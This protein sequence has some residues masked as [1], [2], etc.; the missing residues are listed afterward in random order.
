MNIT[1]V[2]GG[3][4]GTQFAAHCAEKN[5]NVKI[6]TSKPDKFKKHLLVINEDGNII[7]EGDIVE[8]TND[9]KSAFE[10]AEVSCTDALTAGATGGAGGSGSFSSGPTF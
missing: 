9:A 4:I 3:N 10:G 2:G 7:H 1:V 6:Y 8:A 5:C